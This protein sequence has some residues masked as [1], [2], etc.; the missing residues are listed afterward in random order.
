MAVQFSRHQYGRAL[1]QWPDIPDAD[2]LRPWRGGRIPEGLSLLAMFS[3]EEAV[4][5]PVLF[6]CWTVIEGRHLFRRTAP[7]WIALAIYAALRLQSGAFGLTNAPSYYALSMH[8]ALLVRNVLEYADRACTLAV[9]ALGA[10][11]V[12]V[13]ARP[14]LEMSERIAVLRAVSWLV[15]GFALTVF[16]PVRSSLY[17]VFPSIGTALAAGSLASG[18]GRQLTNR[19]AGA[20]IAAGLILPLICFPIYRS[21]NQSWVANARLSRAV[22][23]QL[24]DM[25]SNSGTRAFILIDEQSSR[26]NLHN[27]F[28]S[29]LS[30]V[31]R[32]M[33]DRPLTIWVEPP[34]P[35]MEAAGMKAPERDAQTVVLRLVDSSG[36]LARVE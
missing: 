4:V 11:W 13:R 1:D 20:L 30:V 12:C 32:L 21:R 6:S 34:A 8:P 35:G 22:L 10:I 5:L 36:K 14:S 33:S 7:A 15:A 28:G 27:A 19:A 18:W 31:P 24:I 29:A 9:A 25:S 26:T 16:L 23:G 17:A 2:G 3:K